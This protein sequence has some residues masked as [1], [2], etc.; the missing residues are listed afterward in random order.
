MSIRYDLTPLIDL[1]LDTRDF[2]WFKSLTSR[3]F[4]YQA[5]EKL[6]V[7]SIRETNR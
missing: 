6:Y 7:D 1:A 4:Y 3:M 2:E 5:L